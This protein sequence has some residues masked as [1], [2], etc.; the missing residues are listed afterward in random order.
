MEKIKKVLKTKIILLAVSILFLL[1]SAVYGVDT[2]AKSY[3]RI[4]LIGNSAR[5]QERLRA[6]L[7]LQSQEYFY[8]NTNVKLQFGDNGQWDVYYKGFFLTE[9]VIQEM[10]V[11]SII[12]VLFDLSRAIVLNDNI[13]LFRRG[14]I[15]MLDLDMDN[16]EQAIKVGYM[17]KKLYKRLSTIL[18]ADDAESLDKIIAYIFDTTNEYQPFARDFSELLLAQHRDYF[19]SKLANQAMDIGKAVEYFNGHLDR[20]IVMLKYIPTMRELKDNLSDSQDA[21][22]PE[23]H[24]VTD[25]SG[26]SFLVQGEQPGSGIRVYE[27]FPNFF[28]DLHSHPEDV[29]FS[30]GGH[31]R[32]GDISII[33]KV[34]KERLASSNAVPSFYVRCPSGIF[35]FIDE[36]ETIDTEKLPGIIQYKAADGKIGRIKFDDYDNYENI[37]ILITNAITKGASELSVEFDNGDRI[38]FYSWS[39]FEETGLM[40]LA[41]N[42]ALYQAKSIQAQLLSTNIL[43]I[44]TPNAAT[45]L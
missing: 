9:D 42:D 34:G 2:S 43:K 26:K 25:K 30:G 1:N 41:F 17:Y 31:G 38:N 12:D 3:L 45:S 11:G 5:G 35:E 7:D 40:S 14:C 28:N 22:L 20:Y 39:Y 23:K 21:L 24:L 8:Q 18:K 37:G 36:G 44:I 6:R 13:K 27:V 19:Y 29:S 33:K 16:V 32:L 10:K 4:P 15:F